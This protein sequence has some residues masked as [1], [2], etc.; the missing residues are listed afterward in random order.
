MPSAIFIDKTE[1]VTVEDGGELFKKVMFSSF[2]LIVTDN[3]MPKMLGSDVARLVKSAN[4][5]QQ[6]I[7]CTSDPENLKVA[8]CVVIEKGEVH[9]LVAAI[10]TALGL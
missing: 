7:I 2:D 1:I 5:K 3:W 4:P 9:E 10:K 8:D 6:I